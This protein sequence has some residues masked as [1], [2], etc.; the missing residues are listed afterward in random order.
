MEGFHIWTWGSWCEVAISSAS[1]TFSTFSKYIVWKPVALWRS[2]HCSHHTNL[3]CGDRSYFQSKGA[4][5][6][7]ISELRTFTQDN[8]KDCQSDDLGVRTIT[9][10]NTSDALVP[11][12]FRCTWPNY[13]RTRHILIW[14]KPSI[15]SRDLGAAV[16]N[17]FRVLEAGGIIAKTRAV[18]G[19]VNPFA[20]SLPDEIAVRETVRRAVGLDDVPTQQQVIK[21]M[22]GTMNGITQIVVEPAWDALKCFI[23]HQPHPITQG[24]STSENRHLG[25]QSTAKTCIQKLERQE[26]DRIHGQAM[27][28]A[29]Q[30]AQNN[31]SN[32]FG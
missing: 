32:P 29:K 31:L 9:A 14:M 17:A 22:E 7:L 5:E 16:N 15:P 6:E 24:D 21:M 18:W 4:R 13:P 12:F 8:A 2:W 23:C 20:D 10:G 19:G 27:A 11:V 28:E 25:R 26:I 30:R 3:Y 1:S